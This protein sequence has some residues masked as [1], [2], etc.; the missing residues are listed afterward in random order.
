M[1]NERAVQQNIK[2][3][4]NHNYAE[5]LSQCWETNSHKLIWS[6]S[7]GE[8]VDVDWH[9]KRG[10]VH[11]H[12]LHQILRVLH[13]CADPRLC[14][15]EMWQPWG[16][17]E[18]QIKLQCG[19]LRTETS[20]PGCLAGVICSCTCNVYA[21]IHTCMWTCTCTHGQNTSAVIHL[22]HREAVVWSPTILLPTVI[23]RTLIKDIKVSLFFNLKLKNLSMANSQDT[24]FKMS[25]N[26]TSDRQSA[27]NNF[28]CNCI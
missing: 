26:L 7:T 1:S 21:C 8:S 17:A 9:G 19:L 11:N 2:L 22:L 5:S 3:A 24:L 6:W 4:L 16:H 27:A 23:E 28:L 15:L 10:R 18:S 20:L 25:F 12:T 14:P 13:C